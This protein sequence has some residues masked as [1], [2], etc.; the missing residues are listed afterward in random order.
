MLDDLGTPT[1]SASLTEV[2]FQRGDTPFSPR[3]FFMCLRENPPPP[4][5]AMR[6]L[7]DS[8]YFGEAT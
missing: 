8:K 3:R 4:P 7:F 6:E 5:P 1:G 2:V